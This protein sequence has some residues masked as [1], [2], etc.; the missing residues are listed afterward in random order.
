MASLGQ[1]TQAMS[2]ARAD[3]SEQRRQP[4]D[5]DELVLARQIL[6]GAIE[7]YV[8]GLAERRLPIPPPLRDELRLLRP[9]GRPRGPRWRVAADVVR[10]Q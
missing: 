1:L 9:L 2:Q 5:I 7:A 4:V 6:L 10:T 8:A 3:V